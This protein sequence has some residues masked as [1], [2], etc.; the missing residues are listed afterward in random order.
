[1]GARRHSFQYLSLRRTPCVLLRHTH[2]AQARTERFVAQYRS[3]A[4]L[5]P[6]GIIWPSVRRKISNSR[7]DTV[8]GW[9]AKSVAVP[10]NNAGKLAKSLKQLVIRLFVLSKT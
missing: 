4:C 7:R 10:D 8:Y 1:M 5:C 3:A 6:V 2:R 9:I